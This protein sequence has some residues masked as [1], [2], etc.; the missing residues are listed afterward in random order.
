MDNSLSD[1]AKH[2]I[3]LEFTKKLIHEKKLTPKQA[4]KVYHITKHEMKYQDLPT[5]SQ[6]DSGLEKFLNDLG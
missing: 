4:L 3:A 1:I 2:E 6:K 5:P